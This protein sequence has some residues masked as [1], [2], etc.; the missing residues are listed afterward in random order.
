MRDR[1]IGSFVYSSILSKLMEVKTVDG[2]S[3]LKES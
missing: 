3:G 2:S 1:Y